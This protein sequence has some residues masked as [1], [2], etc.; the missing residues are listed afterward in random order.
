MHKTIQASTME[1]YKEACTCFIYVLHGLHVNF[2]VLLQLL[3]QVLISTSCPCLLYIRWLVVFSA[4]LSM[5]HVPAM[6]FKGHDEALKDLNSRPSWLFYIPRKISRSHHNL[7]SNI[8][9]CSPATNV[10]YKYNVMAH[11]YILTDRKCIT[12]RK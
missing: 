12:M 11:C 6:H 3:D 5:R 1:K 10:Q 8:E 2:V 9:T 4:A 7:C